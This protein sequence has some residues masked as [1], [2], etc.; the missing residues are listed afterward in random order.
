MNEEDTDQMYDKLFDRYGKVMYR[1]NDKK[2]TSA[3]VDDDAESLSCNPSMH[4]ID[5]KF[6]LSAGPDEL[7]CCCSLC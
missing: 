4:F 5:E 7:L 1:R 6:L 2:S 3:E